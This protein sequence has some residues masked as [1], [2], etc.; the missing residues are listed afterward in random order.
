[1]KKKQAAAGILG[2]MLMSAAVLPV[3]AE[4]MDVTYREA[5]SY[6]VNIPSSVD[7]SNGAASEKLEVKNVNLEPGKEI[8]IKISQGV[9][10]NGVIELSR[11]ND[12]AT[13][14][15]TTV[16]KTADGAGIALNTDFVSFT[17][18]GSQN[19][20]FSALEAKGGG[21]V[22]AGNYSGQLTFTVTAPDKN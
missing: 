6:M 4:T 22:K 21:Q 19:L 13:K 17:A 16:S 1:M 15:V 12:T 14:T 9:D 20:F 5:N 2:I 3:H 8:K 11:E 18:N 7:L 10:T